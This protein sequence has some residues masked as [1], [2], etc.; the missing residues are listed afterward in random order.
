MHVKW[1]TERISAAPEVGELR[2]VII[3]D[4]F[5]AADLREAIHHKT[6]KSKR[7][8]TAFELPRRRLGILHR[9]GCK[10]AR[11]EAGDR[12]SSSGACCHCESAQ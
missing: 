1:L 10:P 3:H 6:V 11:G 9:Q 8:D 2:R 4:R 5:C 12:S 7:S